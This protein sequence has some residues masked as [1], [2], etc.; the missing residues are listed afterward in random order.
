[1]ERLERLRVAEA[2]FFDLDGTLI[3]S[4]KYHAD[5]FAQAVEMLSGYRITDGERREFFE[6]HTRLF[7][8]VL[9]DRHG[10][11]LDP[12]DVLEYKRIHVRDHFKTEVFPDAMEFIGRWRGRKRMALVSNSP[13]HFVEQA[14]GEAGLM[15]VFEVVV[16]ADEVTHR[17]P[18]PE[19][20]QQALDRM[21]LQPDQ[22]LVFEDSPAGVEAAAAAGCPVWLI[23]NGSG[24]CVD[25]VSHWSWKELLA[26]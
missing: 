8:P 17:K 15:D 12:D 7:T 16:T 11:E 23:E 14:L 13:R 21:D 10:L 3:D 19:M 18:D 5:G 25:G 1:M 20:V 4:E 22:V 2:F 24:R 9:C 6:S 26:L